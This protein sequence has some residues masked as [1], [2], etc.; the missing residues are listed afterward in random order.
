MILK[1]VSIVDIDLCDLTF[2]FHYPSEQIIALRSNKVILSFPV[3]LREALNSTFK[4]ISG[5]DRVK[6]AEQIGVDSISALIYSK[7]ELSDLDSFLLN[8]YL[9]KKQKLFNPVEKGIILKK[10]LNFGISEKRLINEYLPILSLPSFKGCLNEHLILLEMKEDIKIAV[11]NQFPLKV[12]IRLNDFKNE[13]ALSLFYLLQEL[14]PSLNKM[15][16]I[17]T[18]TYEISLREKIKIK[19]LINEKIFKEILKDES[20]SKTQK[21]QKIREE[22]QKRRYPVLA[23]SRHEF[24]MALKLLHLP[25]SLKIT[26]TNYFEDNILKLNAEFSSHYELKKLGNLILKLSE[27]KDLIKL[28]ETI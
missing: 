5:F 7:E 22:L 11:A 12:A 16:E 18:M 13:D 2:S 9:E 14:K 23:K 27:K 25:P 19:N 6:K 10:L 17:I 3:I 20:L 21:I 15:N 1:N 8:F 24:R 4:I 26:H 28:L